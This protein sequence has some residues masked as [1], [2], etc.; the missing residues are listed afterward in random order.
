MKQTLLKSGGI[1]FAF[2]MSCNSLQAQLLPPQALAYQRTGRSTIELSWQSPDKYQ[3][4]PLYDLTEWIPQSHFYTK[5]ASS[6]M[7]DGVVSDG[8]F[9]Y[10]SS[11]KEEA[12]QFHLFDLT[13]NFVETIRISGLPAIYMMT[14]D[15]RYFYGTQYDRP[16]IY[17]IDMDKREL[18]SIIP[19]PMNLFHI[20]YIPALDNGNGGFEAGNPSQGYYFGKDGRYLANGPSYSAYVGCSSTAYYNGKLYAFCQIPS[21][22]KGIIEFDLE[23]RQPT[24]KSLDLGDLIGSAGIISSQMATDLNFYEYP[25]G[26]MNAL[27]TCYYTTDTEGGTVVS[28]FETGKRPELTGLQGYNV[29]KNGEKQN[30]ELILPSVYSFKSEGLDEETDYLYQATAVYTDGESS[31]SQSLTVRLPAS[32]SLPLSEDFASERFLDNF[33]EIIQSTNLPAWNIVKTPATLGDYL[34]SLAYSYR[35]E[36]DYSQIFVSKRLK[37]PASAV[38]LRYAIACNRQNQMNEHLNIEVGTGEVWETVSTENSADVS[39]WQTKEWDI[40]SLVQGRDFQ[41]RFRASG[42]GGTNPYN[43][44]L[45]DIRIWNP[46]YID[47]G[48]TLHS[49]DAPLEGVTV[50][51]EKSDD[52]AVVYQTETGET[53]N[54]LFTPVEKGIYKLTVLK[55]NETLYTDSAYAIEAENTSVFIQLPASRL[56]TDTSPR[57]VV[58]G[59]N[60]NKT[61]SVPLSNVGNAEAE[62]N[63]SIDYKSLGA[64]NETGKSNILHAPEW[65]TGKPFNFNAL[66]ETAVVLHKNHYYTMGGRTYV[67]SSYLLRKYTTEGELVHTYTITTPDYNLQGLVSDGETLYEITAEVDNGVYSPSIPGKLIPIDFENSAVDESQAIVTDLNEIGALRYATYDPVNDGFYVGS[68]HVVHRIDRSG[69]VQKTYNGI[70][71]SY[72][73]HIVLDTFSEGGPYLWLFCEKAITGYGEAKDRANILQFSLKDE[74]MTNVIH[75]LT[76]MPDYDHDAVAVAAGGFFGSTALVPG[77]FVIGGGVR[78]SNAVMPLQ[79]TLFTYQMFPYENWISLEK[80]TGKTGGGSSEE[81]SFQLNSEMLEEGE[82]REATI[83]IASGAQT[84]FEI[85]VKLTIDNSGEGNCLPPQN[86][87]ASVNGNYQVELTWSAPEDAGQIKGYNVFRNG[88]KINAG[89]VPAAGYTDPVPGM[90][91]QTYTIKTVYDSECESYDSEAVEVFV[92][93][94]EIVRPVTGL[95]ASV[96]NKKHVQL[97]WNTPAYENGFFDDFESYPSF[98]IQDIGNWKLSDGDKSWTYY[99]SSVFYPNQGAQMAFMVFNPAGCV[100]AADITACDDKKQF[101]A[102]FSANVDR[103]AN[104]DWLISPPLDFNRPFTFSFMGKTQSL[105]YGSEKINIGYSLTGHAPEDFI[106]INGNT[107]VGIADVWWKYEYQIP[108]NARYVAINCVTMNGFMLMIDNIYIGHPEY[109]SDLLG[110]NVYR[111]NEKQNTALLK[112]NAYSE[113]DLEDGSYTY[114][115]E[116]LFSNGTSSVALSEPVEIAGNYEPAPPRDLKAERVG[117]NI[118]LSWLPPL[119]SPQEEFRYDNG[120]PSNSIGGVAGEEQLIAIR[121]DGSDLNLYRGFSIAGLQFHIAEPV[122]YVVPF[123]FENGTLAQVGEEMQVEPG[124]YTAFLF[125]SPVIIRKDTEYIIGYSYKT[126]SADYY[127]V[128]HDAGPGVPGKS[129]LISSDGSNWYSAAQL[130]GAEFNIN[131]NIAMLVEWRADVNGYNLYRDDVKLNNEP[132]TGLNYTDE[133]DG[134]RK[135]Y[136][137]S[138]VY[139]TGEERNSNRVTIYNV[140][141]ISVNEYQVEIYPNPAHDR[142]FVKGKYDALELISTG[143]IKLRKMQGEGKEITEINVQNL[144]PGIYILGVTNE[145]NTKY[146]KIIIHK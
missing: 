23:T 119:W 120:I 7:Q 38:K 20:T 71:S 139:E 37:A 78:F 19:T 87:A 26:T 62:W 130:W 96:I 92:S 93:N 133:D 128:S 75:S 40:T 10:S 108:A 79:T 1:L 91:A 42:A 8:K 95:Q 46:E 5:P 115:I 4:Y 122:D 124:K 132:L 28:R 57:H 31:E 61:I 143:G 14:Y 21:S 58:L 15:G 136:Y 86:P 13:G 84:E 138:A 70:A 103:L 69:K 113:Y 73:R 88:K 3:S 80:N 65:K 34:P 104:N 123:L 117:S 60:K 36:R 18:V 101:L 47:F 66:D 121:W 44:Y 74:V 112:T 22:Q 118:R 142:I 146:H 63:A 27:I 99:N 29:Y 17:K 64:G 6:Q 135:E 111:N 131:W 55:E 82:E 52:K 144:T 43:W 94:P 35:Y 97:H 24:G 11:I 126:T 32:D 89:L 129:D 49:I 98:I 114:K 106:F 16:G 141:I 9:I 33:W 67:P 53:G 50:R 100:P 107:P 110:Y 102:C 41:L 137:V 51:L 25:S 30:T 125:D 77:Y 127:P 140:G 134:K 81:F 2:L 85:P 56:Q 83:R 109:Y 45:D 116:A 68:S 105:Q 145:N 12:G 39:S 48:G 54:F 72:T 76:D 90:G 59:E